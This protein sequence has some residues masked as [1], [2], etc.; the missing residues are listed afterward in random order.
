MHSVPVTLTEWLV[1]QA[2]LVSHLL[3]KKSRSTRLAGELS[4]H[5]IIS[6]TVFVGQEHDHVVLKD[7]LYTGTY[8]VDDL[9]HILNQRSHNIYYSNS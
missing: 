4:M 5:C 1:Q 8:K 9:F 7:S 6:I 2:R 3:I